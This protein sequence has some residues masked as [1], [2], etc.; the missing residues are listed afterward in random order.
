MMSR[1]GSHSKVH[2]KGTTNISGHPLLTNVL[3]IKGL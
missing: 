1:D 3:Y 2:V